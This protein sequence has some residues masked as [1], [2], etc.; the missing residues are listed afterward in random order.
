M[1]VKVNWFQAACALLAILVFCLLPF[2]SFG[3]PG[4]RIALYRFSALSIMNHVNQWMSIPLIGAILMLVV[5]FL[6]SQTASLVT[7]LLSFIATAILGLSLNGILA[8]SGIAQLVNGAASQLTQGAVNISSL[9]GTL[10]SISV[11]LSVGFYLYLL[12]SA[13]FILFGVISLSP[14]T[15]RGGSGRPNIASSVSSPS[16]RQN[17]YK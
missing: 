10:S 14:A 9:V 5:A 2:A 7:G 15:N 1:Q 16:R 4:V 8:N 11:W 3:V 13:L 17:M 12:F 6:G